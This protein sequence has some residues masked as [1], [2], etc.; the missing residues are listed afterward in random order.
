MM[1]P[2]TSQERRSSRVRKKAP[3]LEDENFVQQG[4]RRTSAGHYAAA[5]ADT[6]TAASRME[7][8]LNWVY[9]KPRPPDAPRDVCAVCRTGGP[10]SEVVLL[11]DGKNCHREY[12]LSCANLRA[13]PADDEPFYCTDCHPVGAR[14]AALRNYLE[15]HLDE[16]NVPNAEEQWSQAAVWRELITQEMAARGIK[17]PRSSGARK[18]ATL[19]DNDAT[20]RVPRSEL[21]NLRPW[22]TLDGRSNNNEQQ[23][24]F[25]IGCPVRLYVPQINDYI[26]GRIT[27]HR[28]TKHGEKILEHYVRFPAG[29]PEMKESVAAWMVLEE[30]ALLV[31]TA[32]VCVGAPAAWE[33][34]QRTTATPQS[35]TT[36]DSMDTLASGDKR[37]YAQALT[38]KSSP[39]SSGEKP[40]SPRGKRV[41]IATAWVRTSRELLSLENVQNLPI[42]FYNKNES[43]WSS[44]SSDS[45]TTTTTTLPETTPKMVLI[46]NFGT[47]N[48]FRYVEASRLIEL[49]LNQDDNASWFDPVTLSLAKSELMEKQHVRDWYALQCTRTSHGIGLGVLKRDVDEFASLDVRPRIKPV[50]VTKGL[51]VIPCPVVRTGLD[52]V[53]IAQRLQKMGVHVDGAVAAS[54]ECE[55]GDSFYY[56]TSKK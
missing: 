19:L 22:R 47:T 17:S 35:T 28:E 14:T 39:P 34:Q 44:V 54:I 10:S 48:R 6:T 21:H 7:K 38:N 18:N 41:E 1:T 20:M 37:S 24:P 31:N 11:C 9:G 49:D 40:K 15:R 26:A 43:P 25:L 51:D 3:V 8:Q 29:G 12:H 13:V 45:S 4:S 30:H 16:R 42:P 32:V 50:S 27:D 46:R 52:R 53:Y 23:R 5:Q 56:A 33:A 2:T 55:G 36:V